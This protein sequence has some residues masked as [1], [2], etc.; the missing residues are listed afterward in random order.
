MTGSP[1]QPLASGTI[2]ASERGRQ[3]PG[4]AA[5]HTGASIEVSFLDEQRRR[6]REIW[7]LSFLCFLI[8]LGLGLAMSTIFGPLLLALAGGL[9]KLVAW[10]G[11][12][13]PCRGLAHGIG[14]F[15]R[16]ELATV[17]AAVGHGL[18][19]GASTGLLVIVREWAVVSIVLAPAMIAAAWAWVV[20]RRTLARAALVD[21]VA[22]TQARSPRPEDNKERQ[23]LNVADEMALAAGLP[24]PRVLLI[25]SEVVNA[26]VA[27]VSHEAA[28][29]VATRGL[30]DRLSRDEL[31]A[32]M[33]HCIASACNGDL[34]LMQSVLATLQT[35][36]LF[37]T[38]L[39]LPFRWSAWPALANVMRATLSRRASPATVRRA[40]DGIEESFD[41]ESIPVPS[42]FMV[43]L[44]PFRLVT[45]FQRFI[46][47]MWCM[48]V[49]NWPMALMWRA[50]RYLADSTALQLTRNPDAF[51]SA[52]SQMMSLGGIPPGGEH[53]EYY[54][55]LWRDTP[56]RRLRSLRRHHGDAP[57]TG[58]AAEAARRHG[59]I[60]EERP[61]E[62]T[63]QAAHGHRPGHFCGDRLAVSRADGAGSSRRRR[64]CALAQLLY[65]LYQPPARA[66]VL[67]M[68]IRV[69]PLRSWLLRSE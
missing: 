59:R 42:V 13:N 21:L 50:R 38:I 9:L 60:L 58:Q 12:G 18:N 40:A 19:D 46:L 7:R 33:A 56:G 30:L 24:A 1:S 65:C 27:G 48:I 64:R 61:I 53:R 67:V 11:C 31:Q 28:T 69:S 47:M 8:A 26:G 54:V 44:L 23:L 16:Y 41:A 57:A 2:E 35:L 51:A 25:D 22:S 43:P 36:G 29:V 34:R 6:R 49:L 55:R 32:V 20:I 39:D 62:R 10:V 4:V 68:G 14:S 15:A 17:V 37:H 3:W 63:I 45:L 66:R 5:P 52:L